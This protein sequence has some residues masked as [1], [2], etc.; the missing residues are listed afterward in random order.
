MK[1]SPISFVQGLTWT[2]KGVK[3][4]E[5]YKPSALWDITEKNFKSG[6]I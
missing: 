6:T 1:Q 3:Y 2:K 4:S 5:T